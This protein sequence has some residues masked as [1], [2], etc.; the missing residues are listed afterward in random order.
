MSTP[1]SLAMRHDSWNISGAVFGFVPPTPFTTT[2]F[3]DKDFETDITPSRR[4]II[5]E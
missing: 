3:P 5:E 2:P 4:E 1:L